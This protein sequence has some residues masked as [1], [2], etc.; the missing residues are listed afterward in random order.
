M[1]SASAINEFY[2]AQ[3]N[4]VIIV[5]SN[6]SSGGHLLPIAGNDDSIA[7]INFYCYFFATYILNFKISHLLK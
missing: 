1:E 3:I 7:C 5:D 6:Y 4:Y 2:S